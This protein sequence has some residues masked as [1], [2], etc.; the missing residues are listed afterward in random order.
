MC[1]AIKAYYDKTGKKIGIKPSGGM[2][3]SEDSILFYLIVK[4]ILG[5]EWLNNKLFRLGAS[6]LANSILTDL[7]KFDGNQQEIKY[8]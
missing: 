2:S 5:E 4:E 6:K 7:N 1:S 3:I 8:F